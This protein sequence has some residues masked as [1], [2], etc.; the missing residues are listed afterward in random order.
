MILMKNKIKKEFINVIY[1]LFGNILNTPIM[2]RENQTLKDFDY[3]LDIAF[4]LSKTLKLPPLEIA[5]QI[6]SKAR[7]KKCFAELS[8]SN[9]G[10]VNIKLSSEFVEE[11]VAEMIEQGNLGLVKVE[12]PKTVVIDYSSPNV[13]K[14]MHVGHLRS[15]IIGDSIVRILEYIGHYVIKQNHV[16]DW[17][18]QFGFMIEYIISKK[19]SLLDINQ[20]NQI[21]KKARECFDSDEIFEK[22]SRERLV[23]LQSGEPE[24]LAI[25]DELKKISYTHFNEIATKLG[26]LLSLND[27]KGESYYNDMLPVIVNQLI[28]NNIAEESEGAKVIF[29]DGFVDKEKKPIP[30]IIQKSDG[31]YLYHTTDLAAAYNRIF[32]LKA[33]KIIY[34]TD[35]RQKQHFE[36]LFKAIERAGWFKDKM[37]DLKHLAFGSVLGEDKKPFKSREGDTISLASL[38]DEAIKRAYQVIQDRNHVINEDDI[39]NN[40]RVIGVGALKYADLSSELHKDYIFDWNKMLAFQGNTAPYIQNA[41]VRIK[42]IFR[43]ENIDN[44]DINAV[45][46]SSEIEKR[47]CCKMLDWP[48]LIH[49]LEEKLQ[50]N[51][52]CNYL[53]DIAS[54]FH[55]FYEE[56]PILKCDDPAVKK[57]RITICHLSSQIIKNGLDLLGIEVIEKM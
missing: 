41:Y 16:G 26:L 37:V 7:D 48:E 9:P 33:D 29:L 21:Y 5:Q 15:S 14:E 47:I 57:S 10:F 55:Q 25:W 23:M 32:D 11:C 39:Y 13:A 1:D 38:I 45:I 19:I 30:M 44:N 46:I 56:H 18:T 31:G 17:G 42:S 43:K 53:Y 8:V 35:A 27:I 52:L 36:M 54:L 22:N 3:Q 4:I 34:V 6:V 2:I 50:P 20:I 24:T 12:N 51:L 49:S 28:A 40:A